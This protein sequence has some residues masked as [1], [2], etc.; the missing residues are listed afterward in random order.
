[1]AENR[2]EA[3]RN[4]I[5]AQL[6]EILKLELAGVSRYLHYSFLVFG[7]NRIP[8]VNFFREQANEGIAHAILVGEKITAYGGHPTIHIESPPEPEKHDVRSLL[9]ESLEFEKKGL[10]AYRKLLSMCGDDVALE[11]LTRGQIRSE[12]EHIEE[13]EK[14]LR[15]AP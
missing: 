8:I 14:M 12:T 10:E 11:E 3:A 1:M 4:A 2:A 15:T 9:A 6:N 7:P 5:I 13:V